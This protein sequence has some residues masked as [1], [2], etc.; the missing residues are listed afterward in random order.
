MSFPR[1]LP[2]PPPLGFVGLTSKYGSE[3]RAA[4][5]GARASLTA[6]GGAGPGRR[7]PYKETR[8]TK[9]RRS[10]FLSTSVRGERRHT[11]PVSVR[12]DADTSAPHPP[13]KRIII[14]SY[15]IRPAQV[16][17]LLFFLFRSLRP[18]TPICEK[19]ISSGC[20]TVYITLLRL[21]FGSLILRSFFLMYL[22]FNLMTSIK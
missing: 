9:Y 7:S 2:S 13:P 8:D 14:Y 19:K 10:G 11:Q 1:L 5:L 22:A 6:A 17:S 18:I 3:R 20:L 16:M 12:G 21:C 15:I 4:T